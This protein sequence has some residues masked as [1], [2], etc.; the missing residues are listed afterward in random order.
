MADTAPLIDSIAAVVAWAVEGGA[1]GGMLARARL[2]WGVEGAGA[3]TGVLV[4]VSGAVPLAAVVGAGQ[5]RT[6]RPG[7]FDAGGRAR[8]K[9]HALLGFAHVS[10]GTAVREQSAALHD[11]AP[12]G[13]LG[14]ALARAVGMIPRNAGRAQQESSG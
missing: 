11:F 6:P 1:V 10:G 8:R 9:R 12:P 4:C 14:D 13:Q 5:R 2:F 7:V 3:V